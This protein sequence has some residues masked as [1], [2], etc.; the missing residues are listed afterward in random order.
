MRRLDL[1]VW[2]SQAYAHARQ[3]KMTLSLLIFI[4]LHC[5]N[6]VFNQRFIVLQS[7]ILERNAENDT[8]VF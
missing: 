1:L 6:K 8:Y 5:E 4:L 2:D 7:R 3:I